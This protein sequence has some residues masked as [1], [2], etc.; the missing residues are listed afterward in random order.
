[1]G[2]TKFTWLVVSFPPLP[3]ELTRISCSKLFPMMVRTQGQSLTGHDAMSD[4]NDVNP[5]NDTLCI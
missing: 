1:M 2:P 5:V 4:F 3:C